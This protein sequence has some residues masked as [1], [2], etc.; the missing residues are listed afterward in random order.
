MAKDVLTNEK[1]VSL[2]KEELKRYSDEY[3]PLHTRQLN[4]IKRCTA[5]VNTVESDIGDNSPKRRAHAILTD[6]WMHA[7]EV[8]FLC[9]TAATPSKLGT[10]KSMDY[11]ESVLKWWEEITDPPGGLTKAFDRH[12]DIL[13]STP[14][15]SRQ[16]CLDVSGGE[17]LGFLQQ[18]FGHTQVELSLPFSGKP[19]P[20]VRLD[21]NTKIELSW[22]LVNAFTQQY[23]RS[24]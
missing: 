24:S 6:L 11:M 18:N 8:F 7:P 10:L 3:Y 16:V 19:L 15:D 23:R 1:L 9:S 2:L 5:L 17:L 21:R 4:A 22:E 12:S 14:R 20:F 13:P